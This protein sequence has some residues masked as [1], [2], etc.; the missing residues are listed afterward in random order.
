MPW[1]SRVRAQDTPRLRPGS[2]SRT[3][4]KLNDIRDADSAY[5]NRVDA[6]LADAFTLLSLFFL[7]I[8]R[9]R[10]GPAT[11]S[12]IASMKVSQPLNFSCQATPAP[13]STIVFECQDRRGRGWPRPR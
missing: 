8:G 4:T 2:L 11:Y 13:H 12:Q 5:N 9:T 7:T 6:T 1:S 3:V 10:E